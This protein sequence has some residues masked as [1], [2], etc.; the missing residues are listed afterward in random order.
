MPPPPPPLT[1]SVSGQTTRSGDSGKR[2][3]SPEPPT[4]SRKSAKRTAKK[5]AGDDAKPVPKKKGKAGATLSVEEIA[6]L[7]LTAFREYQNSFR[8]DARK[9]PPTP[10]S[11][12]QTPYHFA[13]GIDPATFPKI[14]EWAMQNPK[15]S[16]QYAG[17]HQVRRFHSRFASIDILIAWRSAIGVG[18]CGHCR[19]PKTGSVSPSTLVVLDAPPVKPIRRDVTGKSTTRR[20]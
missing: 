13:P 20:C 17:S 15:Q 1:A 6:Q 2:E 10:D 5:P 11:G 14:V 18:R 9:R 16:V 12:D 4:T 19:T 8:P 7:N 3:R